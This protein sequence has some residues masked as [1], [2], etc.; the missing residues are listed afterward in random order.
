[1]A[2]KQ[3]IALFISPGGEVRHVHS[4]EASKL[5][6]QLG[7]PEQKTVRRASH[8]EPTSELRPMACKW[9]ADKADAKLICGGPR[10]IEYDEVKFKQDMLQAFPNSWWADLT[11]VD[12]PV[13]GPFD[14]NTE[15]L[16]AELQWLDEHGA[17][18]STKP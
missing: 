10:Y 9:L 15:A 7:T 4:T 2:E 13:F 8:V 3:P 1:M 11:P 16:A 17:P 12:G 6:S 14:T 18:V 5:T